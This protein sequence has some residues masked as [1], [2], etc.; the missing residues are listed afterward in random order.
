MK[1]EF[2]LKLNEKDFTITKFLIGVFTDTPGLETIG[3]NVDETIDRRG[4]VE[5]FVVR[6]VLD[7]TQIDIRFKGL[8]GA[9]EFVAE[10]IT[11]YKVRYSK[12]YYIFGKAVRKLESLF[13]IHAFS[14]DYYFL[15]VFE[16]ANDYL[17]KH[18]LIPDMLEVY[19]KIELELSH[20][21]FEQ[22]NDR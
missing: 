18:K 11:I 22:I 21:L 7:G 4:G 17:Y 20:K 8:R 16:A 14:Y 3:V 12:Q 13:D 10:S 15:P 2:K 6:I 9:T 5:T 1:D 19:A